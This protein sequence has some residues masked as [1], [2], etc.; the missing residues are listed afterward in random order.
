MSRLGRPARRSC[1]CHSSAFVPS[2][3]TTKSP[4]WWQRSYSSAFVGSRAI[5]GQ[6]EMNSIRPSA[7]NLSDCRLG[8]HRSPKPSGERTIQRPPESPNTWPH[9]F[10]QGLMNVETPAPPGRVAPSRP[11]A[12][13]APPLSRCPRAPR[14]A[15]ANST[16]VD[17]CRLL[18]IRPLMHPAKTRQPNA[19]LK[20]PDHVPQSLRVP[21]FFP[22]FTQSSRNDGLVKR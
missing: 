14:S 12:D 9:A 1:T 16:P 4:I 10:S 21:Q 11:R 8:C 5:A 2:P 3:A 18:S 7:Q 15:R 19:H 17:S 6:S 13:S 22:I 20:T